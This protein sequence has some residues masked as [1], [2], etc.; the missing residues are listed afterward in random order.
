MKDLK[1]TDELRDDP[2]ER[3]EHREEAIPRRTEVIPSR[4]VERTRSSVLELDIGGR[5]VRLEN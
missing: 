5:K 1:Q 2:E 3:T 4:V